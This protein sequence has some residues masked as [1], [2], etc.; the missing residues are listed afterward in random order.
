MYKVEIPNWDPLINISKFSQV[1]NYLPQT[2][3]LKAFMKYFAN[4]KKKHE[5]STTDR[6]Y[7]NIKNTDAESC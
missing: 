5:V 3:S 6:K 2:S 7:W 4:T 1:L